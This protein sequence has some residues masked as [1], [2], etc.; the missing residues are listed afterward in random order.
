V[1][2]IAS[3]LEVNE[4]QECLLLASSPITK[5]LLQREDVLLGA[6]EWQECDLLLADEPGPHCVMG[7]S[8]WRRQ[9]PDP[10][11]FS[12]HIEIF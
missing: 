10:D 9:V 5:N 3:L 8:W 2:A 12:D 4:Q 11:H 7:A 1:N 6:P